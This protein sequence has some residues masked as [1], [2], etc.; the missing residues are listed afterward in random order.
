MNMKKP[1]VLILFLLVASVLYAQKF[2]LFE[3]L[4]SSKTGVVFKNSL[5]ETRTS[6][7]LTYEYFFN[8]G[9][10]AVGDINND[11]L[12]DIYFTGNMIPNALYLNMG[13]FKFREIAASA[14]VSCPERWKT[15]VTMAD[16]DGDGYLDI[17]VC[18]SGKGDPE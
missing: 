17:Y 15:G 7:V 11:G 5:Q 4:P 18:Y 9:G 10:V 1:A 13:N 16:V 3:S 8:G 2:S 12:D 14:G 6:N